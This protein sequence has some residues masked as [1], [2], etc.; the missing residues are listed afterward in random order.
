M[1]PSLVSVVYVVLCSKVSQSFKAYIKEEVLISKLAPRL[2]EYNDHDHPLPFPFYSAHG[3]AS[4]DIQ[5][6]C[7]G[8]MPSKG[9][10]LNGNHFTTSYM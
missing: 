2:R 3:S 6:D 9:R 1:I 8:S 7:K 10:C 5:Y 4:F